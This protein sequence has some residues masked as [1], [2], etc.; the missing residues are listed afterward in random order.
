MYVVL[1]LEFTKS[2]NVWIG[3]CVELGTA[4]SSNSLDHAQEKLTQLVA[5]QLN[6]LERAGQRDR[7]FKER[8]VALH[9]HRLPTVLP[10]AERAGQRV[11]WFGAQRA[12]A[13]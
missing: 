6:A 13:A 9:Q 11:Q 12:P 8:G 10:S 7:V 5:V 2:R 3:K 1:T 4:T